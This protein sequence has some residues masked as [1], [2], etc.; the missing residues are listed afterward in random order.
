RILIVDNDEE[1]LLALERV[2]EDHGYSTEIAVSHAQASDL[3]SQDEFDLL[4]LDDYLS[5]KDSLEVVTDLRSAEMTPP[6]IVVTYHRHPSEGEE[7]RLRL[8]GV[9]AWIDKRAP[10]DLAEIACRLLD[11]HEA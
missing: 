8:L 5:D 3:L 4:V 2:L 11:C 6:R 1:V 7:A 10:S 9:S